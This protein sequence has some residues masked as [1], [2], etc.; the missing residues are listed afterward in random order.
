V[1]VLVSGV[2]GS[3]KTTVGQALAARLGW[4][5][6][7]ADD[8]HAPDARARMARGQPLDDGAREPWLDRLAAVIRGAVAAGEPLVLACSAL[9]ASYR[10]RLVSAAGPSP[11]L[12]VFL[13]VDL[14]TAHA[15]LGSRRGHFAGPALAASQFAA[16]EPPAD[17]LILDATLPVDA[18]VAA[19]VVAVQEDGHGDPPRTSSH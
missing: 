11:V 4:R 17:G 7:D 13:K 12:L 8:F 5:F 2:S 18:L 3:G 19:I 6:A 14:F 16:L 1:I 15:R 10:A 9:R